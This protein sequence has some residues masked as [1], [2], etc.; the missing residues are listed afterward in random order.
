MIRNLKASVLF[1][2]KDFSLAGEPQDL[3]QSIIRE[4]SGPQPPIAL[5]I[6][7]YHDFLPFALYLDRGEAM[8]AALKE[9]NVFALVASRIPPLFY[10][11]LVSVGITPVECDIASAGLKNHEEIELD[12]VKNEIQRRGGAIRFE[13]IPE[14]IGKIIQSGGLL[15]YTRTLLGK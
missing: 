3:F 5:V 6:D 7:D 4:R 13:S 1:A 10:R 12:F 9:N 14:P 15:N 8:A 2:D 11:I